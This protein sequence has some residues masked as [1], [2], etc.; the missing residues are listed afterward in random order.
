MDF[1]LLKV[2]NV[3]WML[4]I[5][6]NLA[7]DRIVGSFAGH[8][9]IEEF[10]LGS[11]LQLLIFDQLE[12]LWVSGL[13][14]ISI[15]SEP[16]VGHHFLHLVPFRSVALEF[17]ELLSLHPEECALVCRAAQAGR[18]MLPPLEQIIL[19]DQRACLKNADLLTVWKVLH[20]GKLLLV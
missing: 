6:L 15:F 12:V 10:R 3:I 7:Q 4:C 9:Q 19:T 16:P 17:Q 13:D 14:V 5:R 8:H 1:R 2:S 20:V 18:M 11:R